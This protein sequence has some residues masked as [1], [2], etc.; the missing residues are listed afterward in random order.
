V[1]VEAFIAKPSVERFDVGV[2]IRLARLNQAQLHAAS[3]AHATMALPQNSFPLSLRM[4]FGRPRV[5]AR[6]A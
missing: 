4:I 1:F 2:L 3:W 5:T 6:Q